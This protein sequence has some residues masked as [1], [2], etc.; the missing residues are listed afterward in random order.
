M[1]TRAHITSIDAIEAFRSALIIYMSK[2][3]P[4]L[5]EITSEVLRT[6]IWVEDTQRVHWQGI[7]K[8]RARTLEE[9]KAAVFSARLS[10]LREVSSGEQLALTKAKRALEEAEEKIRVL[11]RWSRDFDNKVEPLTRK[12][13]KMHSILHEDMTEAVVHLAEIIRTIDAYAGIM[14]PSLNNGSPSPA[15]SSD[16]AAP[17]EPADS[18]PPK[19]GIS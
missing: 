8:R 2:A 7:A 6:R 18:T 1:A 16:S 9:A 5:E 15:A 12:L 13:E 11:K 4:A 19:E 3:G 17:A 10:N 14:A